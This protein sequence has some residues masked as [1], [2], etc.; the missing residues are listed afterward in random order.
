[1]TAPTIELEPAGVLL[2]D[3]AS[4]AGSHRETTAD[5]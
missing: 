3:V 1:L 2:V 5:V 4:V